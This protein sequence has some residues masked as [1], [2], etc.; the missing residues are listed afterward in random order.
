MR[1]N[2]FSRKRKRNNIPIDQNTYNRAQLLPTRQQLGQPLD[3]PNYEEAFRLLG[4]SGRN[5]DPRH[6]NVTER[7]LGHFENASTPNLPYKPIR[8][9]KNSQRSPYI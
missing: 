4:I 5:I 9:T 6:Y 2:I 8:P 7:H 1:F 3:N